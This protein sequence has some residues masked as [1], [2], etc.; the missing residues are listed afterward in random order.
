MRLLTEDVL[1]G[2][3]VGGGGGG[4]VSQA[5]EEVIVESYTIVKKD[6]SVP[7]IKKGKKLESN[8]PAA[9]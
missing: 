9:V 3:E 6:F 4:Q 1:L 8:G 2:R 5:K 7:D